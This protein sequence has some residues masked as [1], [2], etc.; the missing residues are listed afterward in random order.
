MKPSLIAGNS[1]LA[2]AVLAL[3]LTGTATAEE[4]DAALDAVRLKIST[5]FG[6]V[7][8][9]NVTRSPVDGWFTIQQGS[10]IAFV[11]E[12]GR[13]LLQGDLID[14][15][16]QVNLTD[17]MRNSARREL[18][19]GLST[20]DT[21]HFSPADTKYSVTVFTDID[22]TYCRKLHSQIDDYMAAG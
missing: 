6:S 3:L 8:P 21:I 15:D 12:D 4:K 5:Q 22:C 16:S 19:A 11:S 20:D 9:E 10:I 18:V 7:Q 13:Y 2:V 1:V 17:E 14:L